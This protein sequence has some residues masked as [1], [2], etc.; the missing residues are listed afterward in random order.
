MI[1]QFPTQIGLSHVTEFWAVGKV[2]QSPRDRPARFRCHVTVTFQ[3]LRP[4]L[5]LATRW[6]LSSFTLFKS[7]ISLFKFTM[8]TFHSRSCFPFKNEG[9]CLGDH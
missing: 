6:T 7:L 4:S 8:L 2:M 9:D 5:I 1:S 3:D